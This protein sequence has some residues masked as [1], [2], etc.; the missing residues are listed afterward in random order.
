MGRASASFSERISPIS[1][2]RQLR[3]QAAAR[4][5]AVEVVDTTGAGD[6]FNGVLAAGLAEGRELA[7]AV[8]RAVIA[9][10][11]SVTVPGAREGMTK[12]AEMDRATG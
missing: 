11:H 1:E 5:I 3:F 6:C 7:A 9:A 4:S 8:Q 2:R 10:S 12:R